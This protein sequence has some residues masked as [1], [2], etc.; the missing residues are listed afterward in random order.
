MSS[1][2]SI[3]RPYIK[4]IALNNMRI[5]G[6]YTGG[7]IVLEFSDIGS[8]NHIKEFFTYE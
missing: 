4:D 7:H 6:A 1:I 5:F 3:L 8:W 2:N